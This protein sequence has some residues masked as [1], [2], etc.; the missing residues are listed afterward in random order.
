M[1]MLNILCIRGGGVGGRARHRFPPAYGLS[2]RGHCS[3]THKSRGDVNGRLEKCAI[4]SHDEFV[5]GD[6][7]GVVAC[8]MAHDW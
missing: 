4:R 7:N 5:A 8:G 3:F 1:R 6:V 2:L